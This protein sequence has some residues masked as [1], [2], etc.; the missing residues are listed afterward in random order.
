MT[1]QEGEKQ[2]IRMP[3]KPFA[4]HSCLLHPESS[5]TLMSASSIG[6]Y[7]LGQSNLEQGLS[8]RRESRHSHELHLTPLVLV[9]EMYPSEHWEDSQ[10]IMVYFQRDRRCS[11]REKGY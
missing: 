11:Q 9:V 2:V 5:H 8:Q 10:Q 3:R 6:K 7:G 1:Y 4:Q